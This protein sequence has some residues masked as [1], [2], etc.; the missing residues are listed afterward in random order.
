MSAM[1]HI[2]KINN[3]IHIRI[4]IDAEKVFDKIQHMQ[5][6]LID[7][8]THMHIHIVISSVRSQDVKSK[9]KNELYFQ[10]LTINCEIKLGQ[11]HSQQYQKQ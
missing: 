7:T 4:T 5:K 1:F 3:K 2:N 10:I 8:P 9:H 6:I 11:L